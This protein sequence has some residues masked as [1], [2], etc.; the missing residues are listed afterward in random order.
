MEPG[1]ADM[2]VL[3]GQLR[4]DALKRAQ[5]LA[6]GRKVSEGQ[7]DKVAEE[8]EAVFLSQMLQH[9][10][11]GVSMNGTGEPESSSDEIYKSLLVDEYGKA[12]SRAGG[13]GVADFV[14]QEMLRM[15]EV[16][17]DGN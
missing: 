6:K 11:A 13:I 5:D 2:Q 3:N 4:N 16:T 1:G 15:Q 12:M 14:K 17:Y 9:M 7:I 8:F 10:F